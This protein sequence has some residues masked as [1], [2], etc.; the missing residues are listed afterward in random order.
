LRV[1]RQV[2]DESRAATSDEQLVLSRWSGWGATGLADIFD[3]SRSEWGTQRAALAELLS[4][5]EYAAARRTTINAHYTDPA[6]VA[7]MWNLM[8]GLGL[9]TGDV[10]EPGCGSGNFIGHAPSGV[11]MHGVELDPT[12]AAI[13]QLLYPNAKV[14]AES[15]ADTH[16]P[17]GYFDGVIG[18]VPFGNFPLF[19]PQHNPHRHSI[20][21]HF[22]IKSLALTRP[23]GYVV[24][25]TS[26]YTMD[27]TDSSAR[28]DISNLA[29]LVA[30]VRLPAGAHHDTA[31]TEVIT[32]ILVLRRRADNETPRHTGWLTT[33]DIELP[34]PDGG[35]ATIPVNSYWDTHEQNILGHTGLGV[36]Q[37][38]IELSVTSDTNLEPQLVE[39][40][41]SVAQEART[42]GLTYQ[43][44][45]DTAST[46]EAVR[47]ADRHLLD[48]ELVRVGATFAEVRNGVLL[49]LS[50]SKSNM[51]ELGMLLALKATA[52]QLLDLEASTQLGEDTSQ[53][54]Q[55]RSSLRT[56]YEQYHRTYGSLNR[57]TS[58][59]TGRIDED[60]EP[61][62]ARTRPEALRLLRK[63]PFG[64]LVSAL[65]IFD[66]DKQ[67]AKPAGLLRGRILVP[68]TP[69]VAVDSATDALAVSLDKTG[70]VDLDM[71]SQLTGRGQAAIITELGESIFQVPGSTEWQTAA[72]YLSGNVRVKLAEAKAATIEPGGELFQ[73]NVAA[74][75]EVLPATIEA[76]DISARLGAVWISEADHTDF[77]HHLLR[78]DTH[79]FLD[80][81]VRQV[82]PARWRVTGAS[83]TSVVA[84][85]EWGVP[86]MPLS[87]LLE[88]CLNQSVIQV[89]KTVH[90]PNKQG[91]YDK[92]DVIDVEATDAAIVKGEELQAAFADWLWDDPQRTVRLVNE[93]NDRFNSL[94]PR[95]YTQAGEHLTFPGLADSFTP[96]SHQ[97]EAVARIINEN[98]VLLAHPVGAG[99]TAEMI[100]GAMK[101]QQ[102]GMIR[103]P[104]ICVPNQLLDQ[105][106]RDWL[107]LYP[108]AR[109]L[110]ASSDELSTQNGGVAAFVARAALNDWDGIIMTRNAFLALGV[111]PET[112]EVY[113]KEQI[114]QMRQALD[115][116]PVSFNSGGRRGRSNP[117]RDRRT[118]K[119]T[120]KTL[121]SMEERLKE[122]LT[123]PHDP[124]IEFET[125]GIDYLIVDEMH[126]Y[127]NLRTVSS[128]PD[129]N[130][131]AGRKRPDDLLMKVDYL[132]SHGGSRVICGATATPIA[133]AV[134]E[135]HVTMRY[136]IPD[137]LKRTGIQHFDAFAATF[138]EV[139]ERA[140]LGVDGNIK[141]KS[142]LARYTNLPELQTM[143]RNFTDVK[144]QAE[145]GLDIPQLDARE[146]G[147][148]GPHVVVVEPSEELK[149]YLQALMRRGEAIHHGHVK[150]KEDNMLNVSTDGRKASADIRLIDPTL[151][152][153]ISKADAAADEIH[154]L[155]L[156][157]KDN[158]YPDANGDISPVKGALQLVFCDFGV[159]GD[160]SRFSVYDELKTQLV[161]RGMN[162]DSI[163][164]M[165]DY[166]KP[167]QQAGLFEA[168]RNGRVSVLIGSTET[169][170]TGV[171][172]QHRMVGLVDLDCPWRPADLEQRHGRILR[173]GNQ[174]SEVR[175]TQVVTKGSFDA[176]MWQ[177]VARKAR[178]IEQIM[179]GD[180]LG[181]VIEDDTPDTAISF[182]QITAIITGDPLLLESTEAQ[183]ELRRLTNLQL[184]HE[185]SQRAITARSQAATFA[186]QRLTHRIDVL[187]E[188]A[189]QVTSTQGDDFR[190]NI[191][192]PRG[193]PDPDKA[194]F[195]SRSEAGECLQNLIGDKQLLIRLYH[196]T[197]VTV[198]GLD[199]GVTYHPTQRV[200]AADQYCW[201][202]ECEP[203]IT[204]I[205]QVPQ[206]QLPSPAS[207]IATLEHLP[208][209]VAKW[210]LQ[211]ES[212]L[213][214]AQSTLEQTRP[215]LGLPFRQADDL[216]AARTRYETI[217]E[218]L[219]NQA[220][221]A[222]AISKAPLD[223]TDGRLSDVDVARYTPVLHRMNLASEPQQPS[224][225]SVPE[226]D[227]TGSTFTD[228]DGQAFTVIAKRGGLWQCDT[229][230]QT[231]SAGGIPIT[232]K[233]STYMPADTLAE[234]L[235]DHELSSTNWQA[236][237]DAI[238]QATQP[239][240]HA[241]TMEP[242]DDVVA[243][244]DDVHGLGPSVFD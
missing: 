18:N 75:Q 237:G 27:A 68:Q 53:L 185:R 116:D 137:E 47:V 223:A 99:K 26:R 69:V 224:T 36:G 56:D 9:A 43:T 169:M 127:K 240:T 57:F 8:G 58:H 209:K 163:R 87:R 133:N 201:F 188:F 243:W 49:D 160:P 38:G 64:G 182:E 92:V 76:G 150:P 22:L 23:G 152:P 110:A 1:L 207:I 192:M 11:T 118:T 4:P 200:G 238:T 103:K 199:V 178:F 54:E 25:L 179:K 109:I 210:I 208:S 105:F 219:L 16:L 61:V 2:K 174:N 35:T 82:S 28:Q 214:D 140:E 141:L 90:V 123:T 176:F 97:R 44:R 138:G 6:I 15:F 129:V 184:S 206:G 177:T 89:K 73:R 146:D 183:K 128:I 107:Q 84:T 112:K 147:T 24:A 117:E 37:F 104:C 181:R 187:H 193:Y 221:Q 233:T 125:T 186:I 189:D 132:R 151:T 5:A 113:L 227:W 197:L 122:A 159:P 235:T 130:V 41:D 135:I 114:E 52:R 83:T 244:E 74:L 158:E 45:T 80:S 100:I 234:Y 191:H 142:R 232:G 19:D 215:L 12:T 153:A 131:G 67:V 50:V 172:V 213:A 166:K 93:Y 154:K 48:G 126:H 79:D 190:L 228:E 226:H 149:T 115:L 175:L 242:P 157:T 96:K 173:Q 72:E 33:R 124:A 216:A 225:A 42:A 70:R 59:A 65:E 171:N 78:T 198:G 3:E 14:H 145:L 236:I 202:L 195:D 217:Q 20:H 62:L 119:E 98:S 94:V 21:N 86:G 17:D 143:F 148:R 165:Q 13:A 60:G 40:L 222:P 111:S 85:E 230:M 7:A 155:W 161:A 194:T 88:H 218:K 156:A 39:L 106:T 91:G 220:R 205:Q 55:L 212:E 32:D 120:E 30:A 144:T 204:S 31:G 231:S 136:M 121:T 77:L 34:S 239:P 196:D 108:Q 101:L 29:D 46:V 139:V 167:A 63:D 241:N 66:E 164:F 211:F 229:E 180:N 203:A 71:M 10:L 95:D 81:E 102:L 170:G 168:C 51:R 134:H 162:P